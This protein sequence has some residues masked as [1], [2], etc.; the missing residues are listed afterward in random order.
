MR[1]PGR[2]QESDFIDGAESDKRP[3]EKKLTRVYDKDSGKTVNVRLPEYYAACLQYLAKQDNR[4]QHGELLHLI[5]SAI[6]Q[7]VSNTR[8]VSK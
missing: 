3:W 5:T 6:D 1:A 4:S 7:A 8:K 2:K